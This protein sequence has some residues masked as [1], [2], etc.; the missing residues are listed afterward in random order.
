[1]SRVMMVMAIAFW[2]LPLSLL[3]L[4]GLE[5]GCALTKSDYVLL[6]IPLGMI[7][8]TFYVGRVSIDPRKAPYALAGGTIAAVI[9]VFMWLG[10]ALR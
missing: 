5:C 8:I 1:M 6:G 4:S 2:T 9:S 3:G 7:F 10:I